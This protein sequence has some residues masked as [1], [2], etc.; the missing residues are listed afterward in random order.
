MGFLVYFLWWKSYFINISKSS[1][2]S[3]IH[4]NANATYDIQQQNLVHTFCMGNSLIIFNYL[5][6]NECLTRGAQQRK[7]AGII[8]MH[9]VKMASNIEMLRSDSASLSVKWFYLFCC[10][11][12][13]KYFHIFNRKRKSGFVCSL[14]ICNAWKYSRVYDIDLMRFNILPGKIRYYPK[15]GVCNTYLMPKVKFSLSQSN[16]RC[17]I[18]YECADAQ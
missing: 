12:H 11:R 2:T 3:F 18:D 14:C 10:L 4:E 17:Y 7:A 15:Q 6:F 5:N 8:C 1:F 13:W 16:N 9:I